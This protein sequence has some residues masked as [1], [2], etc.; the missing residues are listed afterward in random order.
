[1][2]SNIFI[3]VLSFGRNNL[4]DGVSHYD[5]INHLNKKGLT[6]VKGRNVGERDLALQYLVFNFFQL[7]DG[8][9]I[10][11][12]DEVIQKS[13]RY[14]L[15][16]AALGHL[17]NQESFEI[18]KDATVL[19]KESLNNSKVAIEYAKYSLWI[20]IGFSIVSILLQFCKS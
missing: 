15:R 3:E 5:L 12:I 8:T 14:Y 17:L 20:T 13:N 4:G 9:R 10:V 16:P 7:Q 19:S 18:A 1:M 11:D 6:F 2:E